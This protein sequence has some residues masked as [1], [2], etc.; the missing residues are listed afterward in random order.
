MPPLME[1]RKILTEPRPGDAAVQAV[2][3]YLHCYLRH[4]G[5][6]CPPAQSASERTE[7]SP[8]LTADAVLRS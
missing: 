7:R 1:A 5:E 8:R 6:C 2:S 4:H 3:Q